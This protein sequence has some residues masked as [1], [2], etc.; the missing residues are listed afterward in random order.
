MLTKVELFDGGCSQGALYL[1]WFLAR[2]AGRTSSIRTGNS[3]SGEASEHLSLH[4]LLHAGRAVGLQTTF[5][6][7]G[8]SL[9]GIAV[10]EAARLHHRPRRVQ[11]QA[12]DSADATCGASSV[13]LTRKLNLV[14]CRRKW[15]N[16]S[17]QSLPLRRQNFAEKRSTTCLLSAWLRTQKSAPQI[18]NAQL[19][20][21]LPVNAVSGS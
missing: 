8:N 9:P 4:R 7:P 21:I 5:S 12:A 14:T 10:A 19:K 15:L 18:L 3:F 17:C 11:Y 13:N 2:I 1:S 20:S 16:K 6:L